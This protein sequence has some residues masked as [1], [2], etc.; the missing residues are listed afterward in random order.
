MNYNLKGTNLSITDELRSYLERRL[1][2][3][4]KFLHAD[5]AAHLDVE[6]EY[7]EGGRSG[8]YRAEFTLE[9]RG[10]LYR[11]SCWGSA[12]HEAI[13]LASSEL[14]SELSREK[15]KKVAV[16][17]RMGTKA[18]EYLRGFRREI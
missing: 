16:L 14:A 12:M 6:L 4:E 9:S 8:K 13:D 10:Q 7:L 18:K 15:K 2:H 3:A 1:E 5:S 11:A 17:R